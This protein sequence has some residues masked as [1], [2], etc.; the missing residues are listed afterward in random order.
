[1]AVLA[2]AF[3]VRVLLVL[4]LTIP[5]L[6]LLVAIAPRRRTHRLV[7][8]W[9][10]FV[11]AAGGSGPR[12]S[13][14]ERRPPGSVVMVANHSSFLDSLLLMASIPGNYRFVVNHLAAR[15]PVLGL[16]IR[17][18]EHLVVDRRSVSSRIACARAM[19]ST[20]RAGT[21]LM[22][23]PEGTRSS[24]GL[25]PFRMG[26]FRAA[27]AEGR[28][29][30]PIAISGAREMMPRRA[31]LL[32]RGPLRVQMLAPIGSAPDRLSAAALNEAARTAISNALAQR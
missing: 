2:L 17:K 18:S 15:R 29:V 27:A 13:G 25:L 16:I 4:G 12:V 8:Q 22:L 1:V 26:A 11:F 28:P 21:S 30:I 6:W 10:R 31:G 9:A 19:R 23:F 32:T 20:L 7:Q 5:A 3:S 24:D 14:L